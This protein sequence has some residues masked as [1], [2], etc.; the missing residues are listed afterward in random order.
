MSSD[1]AQLP[2]DVVIRVEDLSKVY[3]TFTTP[4]DRIKQWAVGN[5]RQLYQESWAL[6]DISFDIRRGETVGLVGRNGAGKSTLLQIL[7]GTLRPSTGQALIRGRVS[8]LLELGAGFNGD[9]SG[10]DNL[11]MNAAILGL[12]RKEIEERMEAV[13]E[14][15]D[16]GD[17]IDMPVRTYSSGMYVRLAFS[18]AISVE[19]D[20]LIVDEALSVGDEGFQNKCFARIRDFQEAGGTLFFVSHSPQAVIQFCRRA[21]LFDGGGLLLDG[22]PKSVIDQFHRLVFAPVES[23]EAIVGEIR[24]GGATDRASLDD[25]ETT[26]KPPAEQP[27]GESFDPN[28]NAKGRTELPVNGARISNPRIE[29]LEGA[30]VNTLIRGNRYRFCFEVEFE[31]E[32]W[33]VLFQMM[34]RTHAGYPLG[35]SRSARPSELTLNA[36]KGDRV[37][38]SFTFPCR[39]FSASHYTI[40]CGVMG[41]AGSEFGFLHRVIDSVMFRVQADPDLMLQGLVD[42]ELESDVV[43]HSRPET[44]Q[45]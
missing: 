23:R 22:E 17:Y 44:E 1:V 25:A 39:L 40:S 8:A 37:T 5:S 15:A 9:F 14:F 4:F 41:R 7:A 3:R 42:F 38:A 10:R 32:A 43:F 36:A 31:S 19:P 16:I 20:I 18:L 12:S 11:T 28:L 21:L 27:V 2:D 6:K 13:I 33:Q 26:E 24:A 30:P 35:G 45:P 29:T 34:I